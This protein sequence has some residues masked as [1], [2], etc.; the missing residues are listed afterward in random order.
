MSYVLRTNRATNPNVAST[1]T[2]YS[3]FAGTGGTASGAR[4]NTA[5]WDGN[6]GFYRVTWTVATT[7]VGGGMVYLQS[8]GIVQLTEYTSSIYVKPS[9][10][11]VMRVSAVYRDAANVNIGTTTFGSN[12]T[13]P[14]G[15][16]TRLSVTATSP[17]GAVDRVALTVTATTG[18]SNWAIGATLD[19]DAVL[20]EI[21]PTVGS[22]FDGSYT[23]SAGVLYAW[24]GA[25]NSSNSTADTYVPT[26]AL[27][28][29]YD[30]PTDRIDI[31][32]DDLPPTAC[33]VT[34]WRTADGKRQAVRGYRRAEIVGSDIVTDHVQ[35]VLAER[36]S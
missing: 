30:A 13:C 35:T 27:T 2:G 1:A 20:I 7:A 21:S 34:L 11:Q 6:L 24:T 4:Q 29:H 17:A 28:V 26:L 9:V 12:V 36:Q 3:A 5:G 15:E 25:A 22:Y 33:T 14:A 31:D 10:T 16:W 8:G 18:S 19:A 32:I 23:D